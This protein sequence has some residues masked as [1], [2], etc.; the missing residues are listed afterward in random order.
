MPWTSCRHR[1]TPRDDEPIT[2]VRVARRTLPFLTSAEADSLPDGR[3]AARSIA[4]SVRFAI[5]TDGSC[6]STCSRP[7]R[8]VS[9]VRAPATAPFLLLPLRGFLIGASTDYVLPAGS[10]WIL[11]RV[12]TA[13]APAGA[14]SG[15]RI[16]GGRLRLSSAPTV[17]GLT[18]TT[19]AS[20]RVTLELE[21]DP[22]A[23]AAPAASPGTGRASRSTVTVSPHVVFVFTLAGGTLRSA[24]DAK[25]KAFGAG[26]TLERKAGAASFDGTINR[27]LLPFTCV[28]GEL[29]IASS[30]SPLCKIAGQAPITL[31]AWA[32]PVAIAPPAQLGAASGAGALALYTGPGLQSDWRGRNRAARRAGSGDRAR[33]NRSA[34]GHRPG[35]ERRRV[36]RDAAV[37]ED[38]RTEREVRLRFDRTRFR[39]ESLAGT[40]DALLT[41]GSL[42]AAADRPVAVNGRRF[43]LRADASLAIFWDDGTTS[44]VLVEA[45]LVPPRGVDVT[46][47]ALH[48]A[49]LTIQPPALLLLVG[50]RT[51]ADDEQLQTGTFALFYRMLRFTFT[52]PDPYVTN[53]QLP[54]RFAGRHDGARQQR[55]V[56]AATGLV[57]GV[58]GARDAA[59]VFLLLVPGAQ[60]TTPTFVE[61]TLGMTGAST[62]DVAAAGDAQAPVRFFSLAFPPG[63]VVPGDATIAS[64]RRNLRTKIDRR[65]SSCAIFRRERGPNARGARPAR[66]LDECRSIRRGM[67]LL[68]CA[69]RRAPLAF[70]LQIKDLDVISPG[71]QHQ[72][73]HAAAVSVGTA[74][75]RAESEHPFFFPDRLVSGD[76]G[77]ATLFG[78]NTVRLVPIKPDRCS[79]TSSTN[80]TIRCTRVSRS[81]RALR[82]PSASRRPHSYQP[83]QNSTRTAGQASI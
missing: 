27:V 78:C 23:S 83:H 21:L 67:G 56:V 38:G 45:L 1:N 34:G 80:S 17:S 22:A 16:K 8:Q 82:C 65:F 6:G 29:A 68:D 69:M 19:V 47:L 43:P 25:L 31:A 20:A 39:Y 32:L 7:I 2:G 3:A 5:V 81:A 52:L 61:A 44:N 46:A 53:Q 11:S 50:R 35:R 57:R 40:I 79:R 48:N 77:S 33:R 42:E 51:A 70:P 28:P 71:Q 63:G 24:D 15:L 60:G 12:L 75:Q 64:I 66:C 49:L 13:A 74:A 37:V 26:F 62:A 72:A 30:Q 59:A 55:R 73:L 10:V 4:R 76:D 9:I 54:G 14:Y 36:H 18:L 58:V 41:T